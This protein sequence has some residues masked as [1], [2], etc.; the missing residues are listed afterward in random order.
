[1]PSDDR[2]AR[3]ADPD[4]L[5]KMRA[6]VPRDM[7]KADADDVVQGV[8]ERL[9]L[10]ESLPADKDGLIG[11]SI[12]MVK[13]REIDVF[14]SRNRR[15]GR[16][17][18]DVL[19]GES[20][21]E[22]E[23]PRDE[24]DEHLQLLIHAA[25]QEVLKGRLPPKASELARMLAQGMSPA[26][27][28]AATGRPVGTVKS[29]TSRLKA[30]LARYWYLYAAGMVLLVVAGLVRK[31]TAFDIGRDIT[32]ETPPPA[33]STQPQLLYSAD[34][35]IGTA[36]DACADQFWDDCE[37]NL[38]LAKQVDPLSE[39]RPQVV[40]MREQIAQTKVVYDGGGPLKPPLK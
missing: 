18:D 10:M 40:A 26:E 25:D 2:T 38:D 3:L 9:L 35:Y 4:L 32:G 30:H 22:P 5:A 36:A 8:F 13:H 7:Q 34:H 11:L 24:L 27:I 33:S 28:A 12:T 31:R 29:D 14:R 20:V 16:E 19:L 21:A 6:A 17:I 15:A 1:M 23:V 39:Q 37:K